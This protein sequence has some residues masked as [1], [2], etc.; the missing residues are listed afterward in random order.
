MYYLKPT[1]DNVMKGYSSKTI[2]IC[3]KKEARSFEESFIWKDISCRNVPLN[4]VLSFIFDVSLDSTCCPE[5]KS[6]CDWLS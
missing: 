4:F 2:F 3:E 1:F 5:C 6:A